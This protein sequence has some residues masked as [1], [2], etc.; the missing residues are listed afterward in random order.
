[1]Q[2]TTHIPVAEKEVIQEA[3]LVPASTTTGERQLLHSGSLIVNADDWGRDVEN[4][5]RILACV[6]AGAVSSVSAMVFMADSERAANIARQQG[7]DAGLHL[8]LTTP[9][10]A[11]ST[12]ARV[13]EHQ[14]RIARYLAWHRFGYVVFHPGLRNSFE[15]VVSQ[16]LE[17]FQRV[18]GHPLARIDGHH[19]AHLCANVLLGKL[20]PQGTVVRRS[21]S[22]RPG[23]KSLANRT[24]RAWVDRKLAQRHGL[25]DYFFALDLLEP[26]VRLLE[27][28]SY[29]RE[30]NVE[31]E[32]HPVNRQE[33]EF[34]RSGELFRVCDDIPVARRYALTAVSE[35]ESKD[36][37][38]ENS[39]AV[40]AQPSGRRTP[41]ATVLVG[42]AEAIPA[43]EVVWSLVDKGFE[44]IAF[45]RKGRSS[46]LRHSRH[47]VCREICPPE[48]DLQVAL[49]DLKSLLASINQDAVSPQQ[50]LLPLDDK[51][52]FLCSQLQID[53]WLLAGAKGPHAELALSKYVQVQLAKAAGF[54]I[55]ATA[56]ARTANEVREFV[57]ASSYPVILKSSNCIL[58]EDG[59][60]KS[61]P[62]WIC[63]NPKEL[64]GA[65]ASWAGR[66]PLLVQPFIPG[67]GEGVF[68]LATPD[69]VRAWSA[70]RRL[71][72]MNPQGSGSSACV[73]QLVPEELKQQAG[74][75]IKQTGWRGMFMIELLRDEAGKVFFVEFNGRPWGSMALSRRQ[76]LEYPAW[77]VMLAVNQD[78]Q[79]GVSATN[80]PRIVSRNAGREL[81]HLLFVLRGPKSKA[82]SSW[83][84]IWKCLRDVVAFRRGD[85]LYNWR[86]DDPKVFFAD[87][88]YTI[89]SNLLKGVH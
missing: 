78:S 61:C 39:V 49:S 79:A 60:L 29:A 23:E 21:F 53:G 50:V 1:L 59:K 10:S 7:I 58:V 51:A 83:P 64:E 12:P 5:D 62:H 28:L 82:L 9:F 4:T 32:T 25:A 73:S 38:K 33:Y 6:A 65:L 22:F 86:R 24:Y 17:E 43:P 85:T 41:R 19:H 15:Y 27:K 68:G 35:A 56:L 84:S 81:M 18:Y 72:M 30:F 70:H 26:R 87:V 47:V 40:P 52:L 66:V 3:T 63:A 71:R 76:H 44:V 74:E 80:T 13:M 45:A 11:K 34:L 16:Q 69:G 2:L 14:E 89:K 36:H 77:Q 54:N 57:A 75:F 46:A 67:T 37:P 20:L 48:T 55:P 42:F 31:I 88:S 8:N